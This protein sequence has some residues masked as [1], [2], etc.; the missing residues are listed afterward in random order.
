MIAIPV[1]IL[2]FALIQPYPKVAT[3]GV[4]GHEIW[5]T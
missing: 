5:D 3:G 1:K 2:I 4:F